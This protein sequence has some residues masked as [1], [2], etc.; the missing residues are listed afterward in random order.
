[1]TTPRMAIPAALALVIA[2]LIGS[3]YTM[4]KL[5]ITGPAGG[6]VLL[7]RDK[8]EEL[9]TPPSPSA[10]D[11]AR[12]PP[13]TCATVPPR[14]HRDPSRTTP[15]VSRSTGAADEAGA[16]RAKPLRHGSAD[17]ALVRECSFRLPRRSIVS[18]SSA[19]P[20]R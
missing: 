18:R 7:F 20:D 3:A 10:Q 8:A 17:H 15:T 19:L 9:T 11:T 4:H 12:S 14:G 5:D 1:M 2:T 13:V 16:R 6:G